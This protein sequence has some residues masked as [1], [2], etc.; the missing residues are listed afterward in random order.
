MTLEELHNLLNDGKEHYLSGVDQGVIPPRGSYDSEDANCLVFVLDDVAYWAIEDPQD[1]YRSAL[2]DIA[3]SPAFLV[4]NRF[5]P[6]A[7]TGSLDNDV[8]RSVLALRDKANGNVILEVG[9]GEVDDWYPY[10]VA[11]WSPENLSVNAAVAAY[12][13]PRRHRE[14]TP[15]HIRAMGFKVAGEV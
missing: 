11:N 9:T 3:V 7:V 5:A 13:A 2:E 1:G 4:R 15:G 8:Q 10:Y 12:A 14:E 6:V